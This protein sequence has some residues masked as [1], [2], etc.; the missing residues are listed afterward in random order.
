MREYQREYQRKNKEHLNAYMRQ[1]RAEHPEMH[2]KALAKYREKN[3]DTLKELAK[4]YNERAR[5]APDY[6]KEVR[7]RSYI[8]YHGHEP[9]EEWL[10]TTHKRG[11]PPKNIK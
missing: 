11:R 2:K 10:N 9:T 8:Q 1:Y 7:R 6:H 3:R 4:V 5:Q